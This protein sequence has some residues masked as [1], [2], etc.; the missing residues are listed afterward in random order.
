MKKVLAVV[1][2]SSLVLTLF[3]GCPVSDESDVLST[4]PLLDTLKEQI[5]YDLLMEHDTLVQW[6]FVDPYYGTIN[7]CIVLIIFP[8]PNTMKPAVL[9]RQ[10]IA[11]YEFEWGS[12]INGFYVYRDRDAC[13]LQE[14]YEQGWLTEEHIGEIHERHIEYR[15]NYPEMLEQ[16]S[17][18][19]REA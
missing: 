16:W 11:G 1:V 17:K 6:D 3:T 10:R 4:E 18:A 19:Q 12:P 14:A 15:E 2:L 9:W 8:A 13:T 5:Y 7:D